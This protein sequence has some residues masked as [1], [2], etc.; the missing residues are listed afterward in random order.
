MARRRHVAVVGL[1]AFFLLLLGLGWVWGRGE[2]ASRR[3][4]FTPGDD[5]ITPLFVLITRGRW[6]TNQSAPAPA[7]PRVGYVHRFYRGS[8]EPVRPVSALS[9]RVRSWMAPALR[10]LGVRDKF[11]GGRTE[12][13][14]ETDTPILWFG[15]RA[16][17]SVYAYSRNAVLLSDQGLRLPLGL[18]SE[19]RWGRASP[20][21][22]GLRLPLGRRGGESLTARSDHVIT[23]QLSTPLTSRGKYRLT[24]PKSKQ[25]LVT[26]EYE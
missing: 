10:T 18:R 6:E 22:P 1:V 19:V 21:A 20:S 7:P 15:Y 5:S 13:V 2:P 3:L 17:N 23:W 16:T 14:A 4:R 26:F 25:T 8:Q 24:L 11:H 9:Y 12:L